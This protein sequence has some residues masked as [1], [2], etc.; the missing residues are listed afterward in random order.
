M[1][2]S[3]VP[4]DFSVLFMLCFASCGLPSEKLAHEAEWQPV[5]RREFENSSPSY[6]RADGSN[7]E[8]IWCYQMAVVL[9]KGVSSHV[10]RIFQLSRPRAGRTRL[11]NDSRSTQVSLTHVFADRNNVNQRL[12]DHKA[13]A[14]SICTLRGGVAPAT[15][16]GEPDDWPVSLRCRLG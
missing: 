12:I 7:S 2:P 5:S 10:M 16:T 1:P 15:I 4:R 11:R 3:S 13:D 9:D 6:Q 14:P 8:R